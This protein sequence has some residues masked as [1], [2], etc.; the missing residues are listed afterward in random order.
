MCICVSVYAHMCTYVQKS[1]N[2]IE[3]YPLSLYIPFE[4]KFLLKSEA[5]VFPSML[6][7]SKAQRSSCLQGPWSSNHRCPEVSGL[8]SLV[9]GPKLVLMIVFQALFKKIIF[10]TVFN[11]SMCLSV[12]LCVCTH[13]CV[14]R[15]ICDT[16][17]MWR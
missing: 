6:K 2:D 17:Y 4:T 16:T 10:T 8:V 7:A 5:R 1:Q 15:H 11:P 9:L 13:A 14:C 12:S 3:Y